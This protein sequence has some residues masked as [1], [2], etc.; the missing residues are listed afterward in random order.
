MGEGE[1]RARSPSYRRRS[2]RR[3]AWLSD[4]RKAAERRGDGRL[5][6]RLGAQK[7]AALSRPIAIRPLAFFPVSK[8]ESGEFRRA[9]VAE[10][11]WRDD[12]AATN[13]ATGDDASCAP[14]RPIIG[15]LLLPIR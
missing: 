15:P 11:G 13:A 3:A 2:R 6:L 8:G 14:L 7:S 10:P 1:A 9:D 5:F 4:A 12:T